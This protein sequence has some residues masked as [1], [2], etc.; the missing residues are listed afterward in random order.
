MIQTEKLEPIL[1]EPEE[2]ELLPDAVAELRSEMWD[3]I[4]EA[5]DAGV[6]TDKEGADWESGADACEQIEHLESLL[7]WI[8]EYIQ[9]GEKVLHKLQ[10]TLET[11]LLTEDEKQEAQWQG[12]MLSYQDKLI[13]IESLE[14]TIAEAKHYQKQLV[15]ILQMAHLSTDQTQEVWQKFTEVDANKKAGVV[16]RAAMTAVELN[17]RFPLVQS[18][19]IELLQGSQFT[20]ARVYLNNTQLKPSEYEQLTQRIDLAEAQYFRSLAQAA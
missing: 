11:N 3:R 12:E 16:T 8:D 2:T 7:D 15:K 14:I 18:R 5:V 19:I 10:A 1:E 6:F 9:S 17:A 20:E 4:R 13:L